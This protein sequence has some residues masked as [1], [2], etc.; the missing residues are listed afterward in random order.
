MK[1]I[2]IFLILLFCIGYSSISFANNTKPLMCKNFHGFPEI[3]QKIISIDKTFRWDSTDCKIVGT[4]SIFPGKNKNGMVV[5]KSGLQIF[6]YN[7]YQLK[8][9]CLPGWICKA[10]RSE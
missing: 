10:W 8:F 4:K 6:V 2:K 1:K 9:I 3:K 7:N 5:F